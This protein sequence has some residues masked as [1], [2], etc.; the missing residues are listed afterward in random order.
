MDPRPTDRLEEL[1]TR[2]ADGDLDP[3]GLAELAAALD[4]DP[5]GALH[6]LRAPADAPTVDLADAVMAA[7]A[8]ADAWAHGADLRDAVSL[9]VEVADDVAATLADEAAWSHGPAL[10]DAVSGGVDVAGDVMAALEADAAWALGPALRE[11]VS[12]EVDISAEVLASLEADA[13]WQ[14][15][16]AVRDAVARHEVDVWPGVADAIGVASVPGWDAT[17]ADLRAAFASI[18]RVDVTGDVMDVVAPPRRMPRWASL[19]GPVFAFAAAAALLLSLLPAPPRTPAVDV[20]ADAP[21]VTEPADLRLA[22]VNEAQ[23]EEIAA[24][25]VVQVMQFEE[26]GVTFILVEDPAAPGVPL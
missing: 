8:D 23:V 17:A 20:V 7:L 26:G 24:S 21:V 2:A 14:L 10:R 22:S 6:P 5:L 3:S 9:P 12:G 1:L 16:G 25:G 4:E 15:G 11:A 18:P 13:A 19:G